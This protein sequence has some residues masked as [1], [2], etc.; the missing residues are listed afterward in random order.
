VRESA[1]HRYG[2]SLA[3]RGVLVQIDLDDAQRF[4]ADNAATVRASREQMAGELGL[5]APFIAQAVERAGGNLEHAAM[6]HR[7]LVAA[8]RLPTLSLLHGSSL[9]KH[10]AAWSTSGIWNTCFLPMHRL[11]NPSS[12]TIRLSPRTSGPARPQGTNSSDIPW[13]SGR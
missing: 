5:D 1:A 2:D 4:A 8:Q 12:S 3:M 10:L 6:L 9:D 11:N 13:P 7:Q